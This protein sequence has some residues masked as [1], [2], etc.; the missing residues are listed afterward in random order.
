[1]AVHKRSIE[2][3]RTLLKDGDLGDKQFK[4]LVAFK[5][6]GP[7]TNREVAKWLG[8]DI[9]RVTGRTRELRGKGLLEED[10]SKYDSD[11]NRLVTVWKCS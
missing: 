1:M 10:T 5:S 11:T 6:L 7:S 2:S 3:Y 4:V 8:W 9:N